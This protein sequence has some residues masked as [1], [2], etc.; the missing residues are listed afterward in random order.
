MKRD[1]RKILVLCLF[2]ILLISFVVGV[3]SANW[4]TDWMNSK[5]NAPK[6]FGDWAANKIDNWDIVGI[7]ATTIIGTFILGIIF[8]IV[9]NQIP[10]IKDSKPLVWLISFGGAI[11]FMLTVRPEELYGITISFKSV[12]LALLTVIPLSAFFWFSVIIEIGYS[13]W[14]KIFLKFFWV[15]Y[16]I[17][18]IAEAIIAGALDGKFTGMTWVI[19]IVQIAVVIAVVFFGAAKW[20]ARMVKKEERKEGIEAVKDSAKNISAAGRASQ[21]FLKISR[22]KGKE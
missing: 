14:V 16:L 18:I 11:L 7:G 8:F 13:V 1:V 9:L 20:V 19:V 10:K 6:D 12:T 17:Y 4:V 3:V 21:E 2:S 22:G 5:S 15:I